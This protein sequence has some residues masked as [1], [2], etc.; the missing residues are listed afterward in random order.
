VLLLP[1]PEGAAA[2]APDGPL[3][4]IPRVAR[5]ARFA[6]TVAIVAPWS[7]ASASFSFA[8]LPA[9]T[10]GATV[11]L[12]GAGGAATLFTGVA[13]QPLAR[14]LED[15]RPL[16]AGAAGLLA[17][18]A[19]LG[20]GVLALAGDSRALVL[21]AAPLF[22]VGYG[23]TLISGL[24]ESERIADPAELGATV[25][26]FYAL[27]YLGFATPYVTDVLDGAFG[28]GGALAALAALAVACVLVSAS[29][30]PRRAAAVNVDGTRAVA[31]AARAG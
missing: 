27:A 25:S 1:A 15:R 31:A 12:A 28:E 9:E 2:G 14:R 7:F 29:A 11:L 16:A 30:A 8:V 23:F 6:R 4:R 3:I 5:T 24:R 10:G 20:V 21:L 18:A 22:G 17:T 19:G 13:V 26:L